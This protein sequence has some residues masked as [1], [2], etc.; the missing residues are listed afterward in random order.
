[1]EEDLEYEGLKTESKSP[2]LANAS[3]LLPLSATPDGSVSSGQRASRRDRRRMQLTEKKTAR[4]VEAVEKWGIPV[5]KSRKGK[6]PEL[7]GVRSSPG[8]AESPYPLPARTSKSPSPIP[9]PY[10]G[11][12]LVPIDTRPSSAGLEP[13]D[14]VSNVVA[15]GPSRVVGHG[16]PGVGKATWANQDSQAANEAA[17]FRDAEELWLEDQDITRAGG[18]Y[19]LQDEQEQSSGP[20]YSPANS[21]AWVE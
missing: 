18:G 20:S 14:S 17:Q 16:R 21:Q 5:R 12:L 6:S 4:R 19:W 13:V 3:P 2:S 11:G 7:V 10:R 8:R 9:I 1:V 15:V